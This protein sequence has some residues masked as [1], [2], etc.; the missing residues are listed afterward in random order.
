MINVVIELVAWG[1]DNVAA[2][3]ANKELG[4]LVYN[5]NQHSLN[6]EELCQSLE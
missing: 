2:L 4:Y 1:S 3:T 5:T 6:R